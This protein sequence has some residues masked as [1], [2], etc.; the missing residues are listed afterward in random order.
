LRLLERS[1][2]RRAMLVRSSD[3]LRPRQAEWKA[4]LIERGWSEG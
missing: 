3:E 4:A 1:E 2:F